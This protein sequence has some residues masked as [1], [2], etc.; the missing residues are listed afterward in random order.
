MI[1]K[2]PYAFIIKYFKLIHLI[3]TLLVAYLV[4]RTNLILTFLSNFINSNHNVVG[5]NLLSNLFNSFCF[6]IPTIIIFFSLLF[7]GILYKKEKP[8]VFYIINIFI[9]IV[10]LVTI[11]YSYNMIGQM[12]N[13]IINIRS[14]KIIHD[15]LIILIGLEVASLVIFLIRAIGFDIKKFDFL[16]DV[17]KL[18]INEAD[19]EEFEVDINIDFD[20][21][22][23]RRRRKLRYI[24][25]TYK[26]NKIF[27]NL[28]ILLI[29]SISA[30]FIFANI[31]IYSK[32]NQE[33]TLLSLNN[34]SLGVEESYITNK[35][36]LGQTINK[37]KYLIIAKIKV[38]AFSANQKLVLGDFKL[39]INKT[40]FKATNNYKTE[41]KD[42]GNIYSD[43]K[44][45]IKDYEYYLI[46]F[47]IPKNLINSTM[48]LNYKI[49]DKKI[50]IKLNP[51]KINKNIKLEQFKLKQEL[52]FKTS[53]IDNS[54]LIINNY[55]ISDRFKIQYNFKS[56]DGTIYPSIE[57]LTPRIDSNYDKYLL[58]INVKYIN[59]N[60]YIDSF[61]KLINIY[62]RVK[63]KINNTTKIQNN[64]KLIKSTK[65]KDNDN[66]YIEINK[67]IIDAESASLIFKVRNREY[68]YIL[69]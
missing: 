26:E 57:Y 34:C 16:S 38:K 13:V 35:D 53:L 60:S 21:R 50:S 54:S 27:I 23:R 1:L 19:K 61:D 17:N 45:S 4:Y 42:L 6:I 58:K 66:Y 55:E 59:N 29:I 20:E 22:K 56:T 10:Y 3:L 37:D 8:F 40:I 44:I 65:I 41:I 28:M 33:K 67:E 9:F 31:N 39:N 36:Y 25:Y 5:Q 14:I 48:I 46:P 49:Y 12:Q 43:E 69:F 32:T 64:L 63:Y 52:S 11:T 47:E 7:I 24:K 30:Y 15:L 68:E 51:K 2:K 62:G 18:N